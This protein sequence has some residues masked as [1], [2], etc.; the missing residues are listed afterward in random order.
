[1]DRW[2]GAPEGEALGQHAEGLLIM[3]V[4]QK[5]SF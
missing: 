5:W 4:L 2:V 1:M 3:R